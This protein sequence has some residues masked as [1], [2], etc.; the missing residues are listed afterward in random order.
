MKGDGGLLAIKTSKADNIW[1]KFEV[2]RTVP[3]QKIISS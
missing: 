3:E 2:R 1:Y